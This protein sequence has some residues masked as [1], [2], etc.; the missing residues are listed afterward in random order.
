MV[1]R[2]QPALLVHQ[3]QLVEGVGYIARGGIGHSGGRVGDG[4]V[5]LADCEGQ[6]G[7]VVQT[8]GAGVHLVAGADVQQAAV[9]GAGKAA[10][11]KGDGG[12]GP[13]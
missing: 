7:L 8:V 12:V 1:Q 6:A 3:H 5:L 11:V 2:D 9:L 10:G 4:H 13:S